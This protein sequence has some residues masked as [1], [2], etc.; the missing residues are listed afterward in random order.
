MVTS[1]LSRVAAIFGQALDRA[2]NEQ[3]DFVE[4]QT[5]DADVREQVFR[6]LAAHDETG[7]FIETGGGLG[8]VAVL[9]NGTMIGAWRI[10]GQ[11]G[12]GGMG[13]VYE[14]ERSDG[15]FDQ[16]AA[17]KL[18]GSSD[19]SLW[20]RF[21]TERQILADLEHPGIS[22]LIDGGVAQ[23]GRPFLVME[24]IEGDDVKT[25]LANGSYSRDQK[26]RLFLELC[27]ALSFAH[28][29]LI[30]H[31]DIK[32]S[33]I[34]LASDG[35]VK[36]V[37]FGIAGLL[38]STP[39]TQTSLYTKG[40]AAPEQIDGATAQVQS[41]VFALGLT[42]HE[43]LTGDLPRR[44][45][46]GSHGVDPSSVRLTGELRAIFDRATQT[47]V[48]ARYSTVQSLADDIEAVL[49]DHPVSAVAPSRRYV[50]SKFY[51]RNRV[52]VVLA[53]ALVMAL[54]GGLAAVSWSAYETN[55]AYQAEAA[56][57]ADAEERARF[58]NTS[59]SLFAEITGQ[60]IAA[61]DQ[62]Q[63]DMLA[64]LSQARENAAKDLGAQD[65]AARIALYS[66][67]TLHERRSDVKA[68]MESLQPIYDAPDTLNRATVM[69][70]RTYGYY[71]GFSGNRDLANQAFDR[72]EALIEQD[73]ARFGFERVELMSIRA[74]ADP[75]AETVKA[76]VQEMVRYAKDVR[77]GSTND[78]NNA[79]YLFNRAAQLASRTNDPQA[80]LDY[81]ETGLAVSASIEGAKAIPE[82]FLMFGLVAVNGKLGRT[83]EALRINTKAIAAARRLFGPSVGLGQRLQTQGDL[84]VKLDRSGE[85]VAFYEEAMGLFER[86][87]APGSDNVISA[88]M[89]VLV[90]KASQGELSDA[91][92]SSE[93]LI[94]Q[95][96]ARFAA[97]PIAAYQAY[98][99]QGRLFEMAERKPEALDRYTKALNAA[100]LA[101]TRPDYIAEA[102]SLV[103]KL[104]E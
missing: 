12:A 87:D 37:D 94:A 24:R 95:E 40:Y 47:S 51:R 68:I 29:R 61:Q 83:Q 39:D 7:G 62:G 74:E 99:R 41:D 11:L 45:K 96:R 31:R 75:E 59:S 100:K 71:A 20:K 80:A 53:A 52:P 26:L 13:E 91:L 72:V 49:T 16:S 30:L 67:S 46:D 32:P 78:R 104:G 8:D 34:L 35:R 58:A 54:I 27:D 5:R 23:D 102:Q 4:A 2:P 97:N 85:A 76:A 43:M 48:N 69:G 88:K 70:L 19:A 93:R 9:Q 81:L 73:P 3:R 17:L 65:E 82:A 56:S 28:G 15:H 90:A 79:V 6:M 38:A 98:L 1:K 101:G 21:A 44:L 22:R 36:L 92:Q 77:E 66:L 57:R 55:K 64:L 63:V 60:A 50:W 89:D 33:N 86:F 10:T 25:A 18:I 42:L 103:D 14:A 84:L